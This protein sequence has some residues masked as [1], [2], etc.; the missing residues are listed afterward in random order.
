VVERRGALAAGVTHHYRLT[1]ARDAVI[2]VDT[3]APGAEDCA[4]ADTVLTVRDARGVA[5]AE[6]DDGE[7]LC[8]TL[9]PVSSRPLPAGDYFVSV[10][11]FAAG[12]GIAAYTVRAREVVRACGDGV[13]TT[14]EACDDGNLSA[15]D[16]CDARCEVEVLP[17]G[18]GRVTFTLE[19]GAVG[20]IDVEVTTPGQSLTA[21]TSDGA[22]G[23]GL[24]AALILS[25]DR[26]VIGHQPGRGRCP[27][28][29]GRTHA[30]AADLAPGTHRLQVRNEGST[31]ATIALDVGLI[32]PGCGNGVRERR[33]GEQ[34]DDGNLVEDDGCTATCQRPSGGRV[35]GPGGPPVVLVGEVP[36]PGD[37][38][39]FELELLAPG[40]VRVAL[41]VPV[42]GQCM[43]ADPTVALLDAAG[44][45]LAFNDDFNGLCSV[46]DPALTGLGPLSPGLYTLAVRGFSGQAVPAFEAQVELLPVGCGNGIPE[47][48]E[49]C[50]DGNV[51]AGD[52]CSEVCQLEP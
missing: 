12:A 7:D 50:E 40:H 29:S 47:A 35:V 26:V 48:G 36:N 21:T 25:R 17:P 41:G 4:E 31:A 14:G 2:A 44:N 1:L 32:E 52:G 15:G 38:A 20:A 3:G 11:A 10:R 37:E 45:Q 24:D 6:D 18:G 23:C 34:C 13:V 22:G 30:F 8:A 49:A 46:L 5:I 27:R 28:I 9:D 39:L 51:L 33:A 43:G 19:A 16:G 42:I